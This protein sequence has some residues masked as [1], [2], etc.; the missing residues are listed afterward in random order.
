MTVRAEV[1]PLRPSG[2]PSLPQELSEVEIEAADRTP[3]PLGE[4]NRVLGGGLVAG[5]LVL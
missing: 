3:L 4:F 1:S 5:S 2:Q